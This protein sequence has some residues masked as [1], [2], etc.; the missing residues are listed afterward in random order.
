MAGYGQSQQ[1][2]DLPPDDLAPLLE[3]DDFNTY[4]LDWR[5]NQHMGLVG[6][7]EQGKTNLA[8]HVLQRRAFVTYFAIKTRDATLE[9]FAKQGGYVRIKDWPPTSG[10]LKRPVSAEKMPRRL[11]W[12]DATQLNSE[13]EQ[14]RVFGKALADIYADG[15]W[16]P[17]FDDY[18]YLAHILGFEKDTKKYLA[19][20][21][22]N[23]I[24]M[25]ICAQRPAGNNLVEL[26]DQTTHLF[27]FRD[28][29][30]TNLKRIGGVGW[31]NAGPIR[32]FVAHL[33]R[34]QFLYVNTRTGYM[35]RSTAPELA[36]A[37]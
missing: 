24:P 18:W 12:P 32:A 31:L 5:Q 23:D 25:L 1:I 27:F 14:K 11:L 6:P 7:T 28:N 36:L 15:A 10:V 3:W 9:A 34:Y 33:D 19:N 4:V 13:P 37:A 2:R 8:Y 22:S 16:C 21:R 35:Y 20:A 26:F 17:V 29:D 30:E